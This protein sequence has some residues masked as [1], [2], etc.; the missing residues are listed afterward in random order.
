MESFVIRIY[1]KEDGDF[2]MI[3]HSYLEYN[4]NSMMIGV[5]NT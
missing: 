5:A 3:W 4:N 1:C 2:V